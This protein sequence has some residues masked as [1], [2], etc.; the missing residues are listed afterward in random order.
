MGRVVHTDRPSSTAVG[1]AL[2]P[3]SAP[4]AQPTTR[5]TA[6]RSSRTGSPVRLPRHHMATPNTAGSAVSPK[7]TS[8]G[9]VSTL[10][11][12]MVPTV[13]SEPGTHGAK[14]IE[15]GPPGRS[16]NR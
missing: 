3:T 2:R 6:S 10:N 12:A 7:A 14:T 11:V 4:A 15:C 8:R 5:G 13:P 16:A 9:G 1:A